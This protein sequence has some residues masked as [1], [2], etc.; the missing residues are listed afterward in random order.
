[1][2]RRAVHRGWNSGRV[3][4]NLLGRHPL[5]RLLTCDHV[6]AVGDFYR[7]EAL[8]HGVPPERVTT[9]RVAIAVSPPPPPGTRERVRAELGVPADAP[10]LG[11][12]ARLVP[13]KGQAD[14]IAAFAK[15]ASTHRSARL[16]I[17]GDGVSRRELEAQAASTGLGD[18]II[19]TGRRRDVPQIL[20]ALDVFSHPSRSDTCPVALLEA[21]A[22]G[23]PAVA[24]AEGGGP[25]IIVDGETG[26]LAPPGDV[27]ALAACFT[28][29]LN[30][31]D[32]AR[33]MG[34][35]GRCRIAAE[36]RT[37]DA[38]RSFVTLVG[39]ILNFQSRSPR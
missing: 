26:L 10:L 19:F 33:R 34:A 12:V 35:A 37:E 30:E 27:D 38:G 8:R 21:S 18:R 1:M 29:L 13:D 11:I 5:Q 15:I 36:F 6:V 20:A 22:A 2:P 3:L 4:A 39:H 7:D 17:A 9:I 14:T 16:T 23:L 28:K 31:P 25:D 24:Y 32:T